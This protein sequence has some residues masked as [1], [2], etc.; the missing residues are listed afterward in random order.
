MGVTREELAAF[1]VNNPRL[2]NLTD[3]TL[4]ELFQRE[5][6]GGAISVL[7]RARSE[8]VPMTHRAVLGDL[9]TDR[10]FL[11]PSIDIAVV[12]PAHN[13]ATYAYFFDWQ[14]PG[15]GLGACHCLD[16][17]FRFG[18]FDVWM[19]AP[20]LHGAERREVE[21]LSRIYRRAVTAFATTGDPNGSG[22]PQ[23]PAFGSGRAV[24]HVDHRI[25]ASGY[26]G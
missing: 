3:E 15:S 25:T 19:N 21:D 9:Y 23:W 26:L 11:K 7:A 17:P 20:M 13:P 2:D 12:Q 5:L 6:G 22:L 24:L 1:Y 4:A 16:L 10:A 18:N 8:R 14:P